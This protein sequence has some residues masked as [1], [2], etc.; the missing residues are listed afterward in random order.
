MTPS[1]TYQ[2]KYIRAKARVEEIRSFY[3]HLIVYVIIN[4]G[5][6]GFNYYL[7]AWQV[8]WF[9][10]PL[11]GWGIGLVSHA[12]ATF[13]LNPITNKDWE[14]RKIKEIMNKDQNV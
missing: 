9:L 2:E 3:N 1:E 12:I 4:I 14:E 6:A 8:P 11:A 13:N 10:F 5:I 7:D